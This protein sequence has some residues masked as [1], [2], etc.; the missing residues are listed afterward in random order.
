MAAFIWAFVNIIDKY[1]LTKLVHNPLVPILALGIAELF[2]GLGFFLFHGMVWISF[3]QWMLVLAISFCYGLT[4]FFYYKAVFVEEVSKVIPFY[5]L[6]PIFVLVIAHFTL[7]EILNWKQDTGVALLVAGAVLLSLKRVEKIRMSPAF[8]YMMFASLAY[9]GNQVL[10]K[11]LLR[12]VDLWSVFA[13]VRIG[14]FILMLPFLIYYFPL[15]KKAYQQT[16]KKLFFVIGGNQC[17]NLLGVLCITVALTSGYTALVDALTS[18]QSFFV[19][20]LT[21]IST[22]FFPNFLKE[23]LNKLVLVKKI[24]FIGMMF[25]G[26][27]LV[28]G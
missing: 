13:Y 27:M 17:L 1:T 7:S 26:V 6:I 9:A 28:G 24:I 12:S 19:L 21:I 16:G 22:L 18:V 5:F 20:G 23:P 4:L 8:F 11:Y 25:V 2:I 10:T 14:I 3:S 15:M